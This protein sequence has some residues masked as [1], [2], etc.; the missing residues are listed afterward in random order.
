MRVDRAGDQWGADRAR[1]G[2]PHLTGGTFSGWWS[3]YPCMMGARKRSLNRP[4]VLTAVARGQGEA[5]RAK[6]K[7]GGRS[8]AVLQEGTGLPCS[9]QVWWCL[10]VQEWPSLSGFC[11]SR[12]CVCV[13]VLHTP[14]RLHCICPWGDQCFGTRLQPSHDYFLSESSPW[15]ALAP[16]PLLELLVCTRL[17]LNPPHSLPLPGGSPHHCLLPQPSPNI[18][19]PFPNPHLWGSHLPPT[20]GHGLLL[21]T[22]TLHPWPLCFR[23][24]AGLLQ[25]PEG[26]FCLISSPGQGEQGCG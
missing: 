24:V 19:H 23:D 4:V 16:A 5:G 11:F 18:P 10:N 1:A 15:L 12:V 25:E 21:R 14:R 22:Q 6:E 3:S 7:A 9:R 2:T 13:C 26:R 8:G 20:L 17:Y